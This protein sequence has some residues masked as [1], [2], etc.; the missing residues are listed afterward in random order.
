[1]LRTV[2]GLVLTLGL[3][4]SGQVLLKRALAAVL[5]GRTPTAYEFIV[6][7]LFATLTSP[8]AIAGLAL[9]ALG[10]MCW[11]F[12]L[13]TLELSRAL[14]LLGGM[15]YVVLFVVGRLY[16]KEDTAWYNLAGILLLTLGAYLISLKA[17]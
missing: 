16:L 13:S 9:S 14:P 7:H 5:A 1:M 12:V 6:Q 8:L 17:A 4:L 3:S 15:G 2:I 11:L 10:V